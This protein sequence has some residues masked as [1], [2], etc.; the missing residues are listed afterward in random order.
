[1]K[2][3]LVRHGETEWNRRGLFQ[4]TTDVP[5]NA[6]GRA[7]AAELAAALAGVGFHAAYTSPLSRARQTARA[8]LAG[9]EG[10][11]LSVLPELREISYGLWQGRG[12]VPSGRCS[13]GLEW[14]WRHSPW[15]VRFPGG[16]SLPDVHARAAPVLDGIVA[17]HPAETVLV[18]GHGH[19]NRV[20]LIHALGLPR[21]RFWHLEQH[22][23]ACWV[24][25]FAPGEPTVGEPLGDPA[26]AAGP[27]GVL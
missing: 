5:L 22:N 11:R 14:R 6:A 3:Y 4:G 16:E 17:A 25:T 1:M 26:H 10:V 24:L 21:E 15:Q 7:Q 13:A 20:L 27:E 19:L 8:V 12:F 2:V 23:A 9:R 18:S